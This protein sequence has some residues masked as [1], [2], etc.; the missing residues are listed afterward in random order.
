MIN[1]EDYGYVLPENNLALSPAVPRDSS[2]LFIYNTLTDQI[3]FDHFYHIDKYLPKN[4]FIILN[5]TKVIP[6]RVS[7][8]KASGGKIVV[9]FLVNE[10][11][12][13]SYG[14]L[15]SLVRV[16]TDR[17]INVGEKLYFESGDSADVISQK[18]H[19]FELRYL[20]SREKLFEL[21]QIY[22]SMPIPPYLKKSP[23]TP[24]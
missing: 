8:K 11:K 21:L 12:G 5:N 16:M 19:F 9:L 24:L 7:M 2:K 17:K 4:S 10:L 18:E 23:L 1:Q 3:S 20:F 13:M 14:L 22:G 15:G 6:A